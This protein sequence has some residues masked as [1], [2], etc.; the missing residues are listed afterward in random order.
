VPSLSLNVEGDDRLIMPNANEII[1]R[2]LWNLWALTPMVGKHS[3]LAGHK[4][5][6]ISAIKILH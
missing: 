1:R 4:V 2:M 3:E 5:M 6:V